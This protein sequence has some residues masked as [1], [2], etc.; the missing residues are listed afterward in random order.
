MARTAPRRLLDIHDRERNSAKLFDLSIDPEERTDL[1]ARR[2][3]DADRLAEL[4]RRRIE[5]A[6]AE[7][8]AT[9]L[10]VEERELLERLGYAE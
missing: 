4:A 2:S 3:P 8:L 7:P 5:T 10:T 9:G 1:A 6:G